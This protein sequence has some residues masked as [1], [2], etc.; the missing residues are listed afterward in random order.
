MT[1]RRLLMAALFITSC[2]TSEWTARIWEFVQLTPVKL[3]VKAQVP[4]CCM[5]A[6]GMPG[7][8]SRGTTRRAHSKAQGATA[9]ASA[10]QGTPLSPPPLPCVTK[11]GTRRPS[12]HPRGLGLPGRDTPPGRGALSAQGRVTGP[13]GGTPPGGGPRLLNRHLHCQPLPLPL[14]VPVH[15]ESRPAAVPPPCTAALP[16]RHWWQ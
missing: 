7:A 6:R 4:C 3:R 16:L 15:S 14:A 5:P 10:E 11:E 13:Q 1:D 12:D 2:T 9:G 8:L